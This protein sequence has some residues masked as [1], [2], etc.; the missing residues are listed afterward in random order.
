MP[1]M[2]A[3]PITNSSRYMAVCPPSP[4]R[5]TGRASKM[6]TLMTRNSRPLKLGRTAASSLTYKRSEMKRVKLSCTGPVRIRELK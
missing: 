1:D 3:R 4:N 5:A 2:M 6:L